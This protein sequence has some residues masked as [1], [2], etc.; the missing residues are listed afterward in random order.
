MPEVRVGVGVSTVAEGDAAVPAV[1][2]RVGGGRGDGVTPTR[3]KGHWVVRVV[4]GL[5]IMTVGAALV[6]EA[7]AVGFLQIGL[8]AVYTGLALY[9]LTTVTTEERQ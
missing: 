1:W 7:G 2:E 4:M 6:S 5:I 8:G 3:S 9:K